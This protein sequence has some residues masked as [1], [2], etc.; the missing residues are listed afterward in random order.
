MSKIH[1]VIMSGGSGTRLWPLSRAM[2][3]KQFLKL[4]SEATMLQE[5]VARVRDDKK[6]HPPIIIC[7]EE[8]RFIIA[9]QLREMDIKPAAILLEPMPRS[10]AAVAALAS[11]YLVEQAKDADPLFLLM[12]TDHAIGDVPA[13]HAACE[14]AALA[15]MEGYLT[16]FGITPDHAE[17]GYGYIKP[18]EPV[19]AKNVR[20]IAAFVEKPDAARAEQFVRDGYLWNSGMFLFAAR[21]CQR[22]LSRLQPEIVARV[23]DALHKATRDLDFIRLDKEAFAQ[24]PAV[25]IDVGLMEKT[26]TAA[27]VPARI[28]WNDIG[29]WQSMWDIAPKD[30]AGNAAKGDVLL[31]GAKN[32]YVHSEGRLTV[33]LGT[34]NLVI[35][36]L[37][38]VVMVAD[39]RR[40]QDVKK[41][42]DVLKAKSRSEVMLGRRVWRPWGYY[43]SLGEG[44]RFQ[45]KRICVAPGR[46]LSLQMHYH[47]S[48]H[49]VVVAGMAKVT[50]GEEELL[51]YENESVYLPAGTKHRL[52]N[53]GKVMLEVVEVQSGAYLGEDDIVR[54]QDT[55]GRT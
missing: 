30:G 5:A 8:H 32:S 39:M 2:F 49:W 48:E 19:H 22:E 24:V 13:F 4:A 23:S 50:R 43:E 9:E 34:E 7:A 37:P 28:A 45:V 15:A 44:E 41:V 3:P 31:E 17:T 40:A 11:Q 35:I 25:S 47:R 53:P 27:V 12:P 46:A 52:Q 18:S 42:V 38:D 10:T 20:R 21:L 26:N 51:I 54:M 16:T 14:A 1:P 6:F 33:A 55:Y 29:S 36:S